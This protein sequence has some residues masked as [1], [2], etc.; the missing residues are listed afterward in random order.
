VY[1]K[2]E[3]GHLGDG[4]ANRVVYRSVRDFTAMN[5]GNGYIEQER[6][7]AC[8]KNLV[9]ISKNQKDVRSPSTQGLCH[10]EGHLRERVDCVTPR[11]KGGM[12]AEVYRLCD[13]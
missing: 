12:Y 6:R 4:V 7:R 13:V 9:A 2:V 8:S 10:T 5:M 11:V 3:G 1:W